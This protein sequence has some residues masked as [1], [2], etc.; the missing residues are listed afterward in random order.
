MEQVKITIDGR[1][2][3]GNK[4]QTILNIAAENGIEIPNMCYHKELK[5]Y[6][7]CGLCVVEAEGM[8]KLMRSCA[9]T[10]EKDGMVIHTDTPR[11]K[12]A[13]KIALELLMSDHEG[14]C[15]GPCVLRSEEHTSELQSPS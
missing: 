10:V 3:V 4:G 6:G 7:A 2:L 1:E 14:D 12:Q 11:V 8:P 13:R 9:T 5:V 15:K